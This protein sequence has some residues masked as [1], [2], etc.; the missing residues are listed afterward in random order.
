MTRRSPRRPP[1]PRTRAHPRRPLGRPVARRSRRRRREGRAAG[2]GRRHP[3][4]GP[5]LRRGH[6][7][8]APLGR[9]FPFLQPRQALDRRR[10]RDARGPGASC[11]ARRA[12]RRADR[13]LQGR[14][15][16]EIRAR[17]RRA[18]SAVNPRLIYCSITGFGQTGPYAPRAGYDFMIQGMGGIMDLTGEP[19]GEPQKAGVAIADI[20][21][22]VYAAI[23]ILAALRQRDAT[24]EGCASSTWRCSTRRSRVL[25]NQAL[26]YLVS[27]K[28]RRRGWATRTR[29][30]C[31]T[32]SSRSPTATSSSRSATTA[33][34]RKLCAVLG[35]PDLAARRALPHQRGPRAQPRRAG[36]ALHRT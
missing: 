7:R 28:C 35:V 11:A 10:F 1:G 36:A 18:C 30:S 13:E 14:R 22:G 21:T 20:F 26:N 12:R 9:L 16:R 17:L 23:A 19:D 8:R 5:A 15:P 25:A 29:T 33:S 31:P 34:S 27:G 2:S 32:R 6:G 4:L 24:G 3:R